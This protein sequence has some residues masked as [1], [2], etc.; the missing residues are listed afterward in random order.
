MGELRHHP[1]QRDIGDR[2]ISISASNGAMDAGKPGLLQT[3]E[4]SLRAWLW[5]LPQCRSVGL[6]LLVQ[7]ECL[8]SMLDVRRD[9]GV[10][11][12]I[13]A[14]LLGEQWN[15]AEEFDLWDAE[16]ADGVPHSD[17]LDWNSRSCEAGL[18]TGASA[19]TAHLREPT[20]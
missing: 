13:F 1:R 4:M 18:R 3:L 5:R 14:V 7:G 6:S 8:I 20:W 11:E 17:R 9:L 15:E 12:G 2:G 16:A 19:E 10:N